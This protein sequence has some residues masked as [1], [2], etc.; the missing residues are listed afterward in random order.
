MQRQLLK[1]KIH[2]AI[3]T[4]ANL[5]YTGSLTLGHVLTTAA[6]L[7]A[8][9][10]VHITNVNNGVHWMTYVII[11]DDHSNTVCLNGSAARH[12]APGDPVII[13]AYGYY[14]AHE[15]ALARPRLVYVDETNHIARV[16][17]A[18]APFERWDTSS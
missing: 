7:F 2:R 12:F 14:D 15:Y 10:L 8:H 11:D 9:E 6:D 5:N 16:V 17:E 3:V 18:E 4:E 1:S 13:M